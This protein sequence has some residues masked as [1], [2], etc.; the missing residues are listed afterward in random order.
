MSTIA[1]RCRESVQSEALYTKVASRYDTVFER[2]ILAEGRLTDVLR[3]S[4]T[5]RDVLDL[6]C[7]NG[8]W[9]SRFK[10]GSYVGIDLSAAMLDEGRKRYPAAR[11]IQADMTE[12][13]LPDET[14][15]GVISMFGAMGHLRCT[16]K[17]RWSA[18]FGDCCAPAA[19]SC[20][21]TAI[22]FEQDQR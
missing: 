18:R 17:T 22:L 20:S 5:G 19:W 11:F 2:A 7:G 1:M 9:L 3:S 12:V 6:A 16:T 4:L 10:P 8:R 14:F 21:P 15:D 13:P